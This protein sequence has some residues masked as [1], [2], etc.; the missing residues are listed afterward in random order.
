MKGFHTWNARIPNAVLALS[1]SPRRLMTSGKIANINVPTNFGK[2]NVVSPATY[3]AAVAAD[4]TEVVEKSSKAMA[5][6]VKA[7]AFLVAFIL[8]DK[9]RRE[10]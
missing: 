1:L 10:D 8:P 6:P 3:S 4:T 2:G 5:P 9:K 7:T